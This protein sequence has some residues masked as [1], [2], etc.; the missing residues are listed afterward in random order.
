MKMKRFLVSM[1]AIL[2]VSVSTVLATPISA[3]AEWCYEGQHISISNKLICGSFKYRD[4]DY[5]TCSGSHQ[6]YTSYYATTQQCIV[7]KQS[8]SFSSHIHQ[9]CQ[10]SVCYKSGCKL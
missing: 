2:A 1:L 7:C 8:V 5:W 10:T 3:T 9:N 6:T 4:I